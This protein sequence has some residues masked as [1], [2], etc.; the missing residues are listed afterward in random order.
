LLG[1]RLGKETPRRRV[2][3]LPAGAA[4]RLGRQ[5]IRLQERFQAKWWPVR[6]RKTRQIK[7]LSIQ[8]K[9]KRL[10][11]CTTVFAIMQWMPLEPLTVCVTRKSAARLQSV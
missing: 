2:S 4:N 7:I 5:L 1:S 9:R 3:D 10:Y 8:S 11:P 6:V